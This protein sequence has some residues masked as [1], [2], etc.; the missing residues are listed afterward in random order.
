MYMYIYIYTVCVYIYMYKEIDDNIYNHLRRARS[1]Y[2]L[3]RASCKWP[4][5]QPLSRTSRLRPPPQKK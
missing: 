2:R 1:H 3:G 5:P 4:R